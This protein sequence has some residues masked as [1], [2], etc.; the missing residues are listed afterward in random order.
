MDLQSNLA[1]TQVRG[2][3]LV[4]QTSHDQRQDLALAW[5]Q[6]VVA[7]PQ[8]LPPGSLGTTLAILVECGVHQPQQR[9]AA[10]RLGQKIQRTRLDGADAGGNIAVAGDE[11]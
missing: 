6:R 7:A 8:T 5:G 2:S 3:L 10:E 4:E 9:R 1:D 11:D